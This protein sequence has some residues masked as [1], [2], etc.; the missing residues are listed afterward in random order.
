[1]VTTTTKDT[2]KNKRPLSVNLLQHYIRHL[3]EIASRHASVLSHN[4]KIQSL[5]SREV[6]TAKNKKQSIIPPNSTL[7]HVSQTGGQPI[8]QEQEAL[9]LAATPNQTI[10]IVK[11]DA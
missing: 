2:K 1:M 7:L 11:R 3:I 8:S 5:P 10:K 9:L 6:S 4:K